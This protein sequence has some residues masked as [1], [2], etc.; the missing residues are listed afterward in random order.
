MYE[1]SVLVLLQ[2]GPRFR[3]ALE[4]DTNWAFNLA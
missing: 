2:C 1:F 3:E 4:L